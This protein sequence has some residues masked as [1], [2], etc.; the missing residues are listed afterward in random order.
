M[1][2]TVIILLLVIIPLL[3]ARHIRHYHEYVLRADM[4]RQNYVYVVFVIYL[5]S[6]FDCCI[7]DTLFLLISIKFSKIEYNAVKIDKNKSGKLYIA[8]LSLFDLCVIFFCIRIFF[9]RD[10]ID[11]FTAK[12]PQNTKKIQYV[13]RISKLYHFTYEK[14]VE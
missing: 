12:Y 13:R 3:T 10:I 11:R 7:A 14:A 2:C 9:L 4:P 8:G 5:K 1:L 6:L